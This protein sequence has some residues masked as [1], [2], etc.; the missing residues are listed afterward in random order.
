MQY[1]NRPGCCAFASVSPLML[2]QRGRG[3]LPLVSCPGTL[4]AASSPPTALRLPP[5]TA[6]RLP[7]T[8][9]SCCRLGWLYRANSGAPALLDC[10]YH[11]DNANMPIH[12]LAAG[13][14][15]WCVHLAVCHATTPGHQCTLA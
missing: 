4:P 8:W 13:P 6:L 15:G 11:Q 3:E 10:V 9:P 5:P 12:Y 14:T 2:A 7:D 1:M